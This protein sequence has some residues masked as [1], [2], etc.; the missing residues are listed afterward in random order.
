MGN[1]VSI[2][3]PSYNCGQYINK[4][5]DSVLSQT[6]KN[7][8]MFVIDD[9]SKDDTKEV[10]EQYIEKFKKN[11]KK[12]QYIY[13]ENTGL[14]NINGKYLVWPDADDW[15]ETDT[16]IADLVDVFENSPDNVG[17]VRGMQYI[18]DEKTFEIVGK[19]GDE[20]RNYPKNLSEQCLFGGWDWWFSPGSNM[21]KTEHLFYYYPNKEIY[22]KNFFGQN[23]Q[24]QFPIL[25]NYDCITM[26][27]YIYNVRQNLN[28]DSRKKIPYEKQILRFTELKNMQITLFDVVKNI[29]IAEKNN[30]LNKINLNFDINCINAAFNNKNKKDVKYFYY[31]LLINNPK[32]A[33]IYKW[34]YW[35]SQLPFG[36]F[37]YKIIVF[38]IN[39]PKRIIRKILGQKLTAKI[40]S[41]LNK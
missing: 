8:E 32:N 16:A 29:P 2:I 15:Y 38:I 36:F 41:V 30:L 24:L 17:I 10:V 5:L 18:R 7:I 14:R 21:I 13:Q 26:N 9:G 12:L 11:D 39:Q 40:K 33:N 23:I 4:L 20:T 27:K 6:Y 25:F 19:N 34:E 31:D 3:T 28:S 35:V 37:I 1:L 22:W